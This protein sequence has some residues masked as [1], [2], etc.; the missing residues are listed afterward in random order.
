MLAWQ[1]NM[2]IQYVLNAYACVM[3]VASYIQCKAEGYKQ[4]MERNRMIIMEQVTATMTHIVVITLSYL[5]V[6]NLTINILVWG[7]WP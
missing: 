4:P 3:Y 7:T 1:A 5:A 6:A 2:D